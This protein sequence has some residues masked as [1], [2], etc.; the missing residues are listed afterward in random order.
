MCLSWKTKKEAI[1][2]PK[3]AY[4]SS[5]FLNEQKLFSHVTQLGL[6]AGYDSPALEEG[7]SGELSLGSMASASNSINTERAGV[8]ADIGMRAKLFYVFYVSQNQS[9]PYCYLS[10]SS[11]PI[12]F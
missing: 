7:L 5:P 11:C 2:E 9:M 10:S 3:T 12:N 8:F 1:G 6:A 4:G